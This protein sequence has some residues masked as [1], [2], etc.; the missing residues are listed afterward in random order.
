MSNDSQH[1]S[2]ST[3]EHIMCH[4]YRFHFGHIFIML[5]TIMLSSFNIEEYSVANKPNL[6][7]YIKKD[8][9]NICSVQGNSFT[10]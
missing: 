8:F 3:M 5:M 6:M 10:I 9:K 2:L 1:E 4:I 7:I